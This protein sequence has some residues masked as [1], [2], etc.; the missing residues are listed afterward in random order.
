MSTADRRRISLEQ[1]AE[2][3]FQTSEPTPQQV[4]KV[5][6]LIERGALA[7][8]TQGKW[9]TSPE[10]VAKYLAMASLHKSTSAGKSP[11]EKERSRRQREADAD[12]RPIYSDL[13]KDYFLTVLR[14]RYSRKKSKAFQ[15]AVWAGQIIGISVIF[16]SCLWLIIR[17]V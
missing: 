8:S 7:G 10:S 9:T 2:I 6:T 11:Q 3:M 17:E 14:R 1:A 5:R 12:I 13:M 4:A 16:L 15:R